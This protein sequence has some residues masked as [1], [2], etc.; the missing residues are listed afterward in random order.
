M[1]NE[2]LFNKD[3]SI[4]SIGQFISL[5]GNSLQRFSLSLLILD[6]TGSAAVFSGILALTFLPQ[7]FLAPFGGALADRVSKKRIMVALDF[8]CAALLLIY[9][10]FFLRGN[11]TSTSSIAVLM[12]I[13][14]VIGSIYDPCVRASI[15]AITAQENLGSANSVVS[16]VSSLTSLL[17]PVAAGFL[18]GIYGI[19]PV[20]M[21]N[22]ISFFLSAVMELFLTI[23]HVQTKLDGSVAGTFIRDIRQT[24]H[25][26]VKE[27][28]IIVQ[29]LLISCSFNLFLTPVYT[30]GVP[31]ME[32]IIFGVSDQLYGISEGCV[33]AG[34]IIGALLC[35]IISKKVTFDK[36]YYYF[37]VLIALIIGMGAC[38]LPIVLGTGDVSYLSYGLFTGIGFLFAVVLAIINIMCMTYMQLEIPMELMGKAMALVTAASTALMPVGQV[39]FGLLYDA[40]AAMTWVIYILVAVFCTI[41]TIVTYRMIHRAVAEGTLIPG[42]K[43]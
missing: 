28:P 11:S 30:V 38:S 14:A 6:I 43:M 40:F 36:L 35:G 16:V 19:Y 10:L 5:F 26:L 21:F 33:G 22:I 25:Y 42:R 29:I 23:P 13:M 20:F 1:N 17:G 3:F 32:K 34:M 24:F 2:R 8:S 37:Y 9:T 12:C 31:F 41:A 7:I 15:P 18:Y 39:V 4:M 27:K